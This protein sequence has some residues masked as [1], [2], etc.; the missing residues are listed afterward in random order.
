MTNCPFCAAE[1]G[2]RD[3]VCKNCKQEIVGPWSGVETADERARS[4]K[5]NR[6]LVLAILAGIGAYVWRQRPDWLPAPLRELSRSLSAPAAA[7]VVSPP[8]AVPPL[9]LV[10]WRWWVDK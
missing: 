5:G 2:A 1:G 9:E 10:E 3:A 8:V 6:F 7:P 4:R